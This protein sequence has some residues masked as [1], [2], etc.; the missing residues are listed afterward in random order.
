MIDY[1]EQ[2]GL[3]K[4]QILCSENIYFFV[5][6]SMTNSWDKSPITRTSSRTIRSA[7]FYVQKKKNNNTVQF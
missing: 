6:S 5:S 4:K 2:M 1:V 7:K 3:T